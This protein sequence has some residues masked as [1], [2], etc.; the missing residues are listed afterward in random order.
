MSEATTFREFVAMHSPKNRT[1]DNSIGTRCLLRTLCQS[2]HEKESCQVKLTVYGLEPETR[3]EESHDHCPLSILFQSIDLESH[4]LTS[5]HPYQFIYE[6]IP[7]EPTI[8]FPPSVASLLP[9]SSQ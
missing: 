2:R 6:V 8:L 7:R 1:F 3:A 5:S 9:T 4:C